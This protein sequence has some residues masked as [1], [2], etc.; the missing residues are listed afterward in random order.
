M[1]RVNNKLIRINGGLVR[2]IEPPHEVWVDLGSTQY[3]GLKGGNIFALTGMPSS[4]P[5]NYIAFI[6]DAM[7]DSGGMAADIYFNKSDVHEDYLWHCRAHMWLPYIGFVGITGAVTG[8]TTEDG[9]TIESKNRDGVE[10]KMSPSWNSDSIWHKIKIVFDRTDYK[11]YFYLDG[12]LLGYVTMNNDML[13]CTHIEL[14]K[15]QSSG[16][17]SH[18]KNVKVAGFS[19]LDAAKNYNG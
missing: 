13:N 3:D 17:N 8:W 12:T 19:T 1:L 9:I 15:E 6:M 18:V 2:Y 11:G 14:L 7:Y 5:L 16:T 4:T 10:Y